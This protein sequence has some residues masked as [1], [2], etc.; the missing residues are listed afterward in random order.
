VEAEIGLAIVSIIFAIILYI[1]MIALMMFLTYLIIKWAINHSRLNEHL[2]AIRQELH[3]LNAQ[4]H[5]SRQTGTVA[6]AGTGNAGSAG[7]GNAGSAGAGSS[8]AGE[9][10]D[11]E[12]QDG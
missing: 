2:I 7:A 1:G 8:G 11:G 4:L 5:A 10:G 6:A 12:R 3:Y 9:T